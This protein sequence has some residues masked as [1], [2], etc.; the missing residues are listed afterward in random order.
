MKEGRVQLAMDYS[1]DRKDRDARA[2]EWIIDGL[3]EDSDLERL[4]R[5]IPDSFKSTWGKSVLQAVIDKTKKGRILVR[6]LTIHQLFPR[7][8]I[9]PNPLKIFLLIIG[10]HACSRRAR[11][12][13][14]SREKQSGNNAPALALVLLYRSCSPWNTSG[15]GFPKKKSRPWHR[16]FSTSTTLER[17]AM[18]RFEKLK[19]R[20]HHY[21]N[22][23]RPP[24][25]VGH[26]C[27]RL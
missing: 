7:A 3:T 4:V 14:A 23:I 9:D 12:P 15:H 24:A 20:R 2:I 6:V 10:L 27:R 18:R 16:C 19:L 17:S 11:I 1:E 5:N 21:R 8:L 25:F 22:S 13:A 26:A